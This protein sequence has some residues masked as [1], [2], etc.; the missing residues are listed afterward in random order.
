MKTLNFNQM[1]NV[2]GGV[3][4][5]AACGISVGVAIGLPNPFTIAAAMLICLSGDTRT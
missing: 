3:S 4:Q 2:E 1:E 5:E